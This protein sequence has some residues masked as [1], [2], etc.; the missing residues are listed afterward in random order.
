[1]TRQQKKKIDESHVEEVRPTP[2]LCLSTM[3]IQ[4]AGFC[5]H[6]LEHRWITAHPAQVLIVEETS[7][8]ALRLSTGWDLEFSRC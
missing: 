8:I 5:F 6:R 2:F 3:R 7:A 4:F 1:M